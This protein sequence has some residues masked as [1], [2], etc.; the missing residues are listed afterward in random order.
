MQ[1]I[2]A[3]FLLKFFKDYMKNYLILSFFTATL[4]YATDSKSVSNEEGYGV[5]VICY[6]HKMISIPTKDY[7]TDSIKT[8]ESAKKESG[9]KFKKEREEERKK[10]S[11][12]QKGITLTK[13][14]IDFTEAVE[15]FG[16]LEITN[17]SI[18]Q[19]KI[20]PTVK[21]ETLEKMDQTLTD[22]FDDEHENR[23]NYADN[24]NVSED[25][26]EDED[27]DEEEEED[28]EP[29]KK[30]RRTGSLTKQFKSDSDDEQGSCSKDATPP[31]HRTVTSFIVNVL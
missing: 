14:K 10:N 8:Y 19:P 11:K 17:L 20:T 5:E 12:Y 9:K 7:K 13:K 30:R 25:I 2:I 31:F 26:Y 15:K 21:A 27:E 22:F 3:Q 6:N 23:H 4:I 24:E 28:D 1:G 18:G 16:L 29:A